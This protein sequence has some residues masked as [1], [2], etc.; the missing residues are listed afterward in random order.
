MNDLRSEPAETKLPPGA[1]DAE[2]MARQRRETFQAIAACFFFLANAVI[3]IGALPLEDRNPALVGIFFQATVFAIWLGAGGSRFWIR[4][5]AFAGS[6]YYFWFY[7]LRME[8]GGPF[9]LA[10]VI[11]LLVL[12]LA[13]AS[14]TLRMILHWQTQP[15]PF[16]QFSLGELLAAVTTLAIVLAVWSRPLIEYVNWEGDSRIRLSLSHVAWFGLFAVPA[17]LLVALPSFCERP[18]NRWRAYYAS[19]GLCVALFV[20]SFFLHAWRDGGFSANEFL[21]GFL[22]TA[23]FLVVASY[24]VFATESAL[25]ILGIAFARPF[26][27]PKRSQ[28]APATLRSECREKPG[29]AGRDR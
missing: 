24:G 3:V 11:G 14:A 27:F 5:L 15:S 17:T 6:Y 26:V 22:G 29:E 20:V 25:Q 2:A 16:R 23:L 28:S 1:K 19:L 7:S 13:A 21:S 9:S 18:K 10:I 4:G 8:T 12:M